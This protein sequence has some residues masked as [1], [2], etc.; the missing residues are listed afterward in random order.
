MFSNDLVGVAVLISA[1]GAAA[2]IIGGLLWLMGEA[3]TGE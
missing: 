2:C 3:L 1:C